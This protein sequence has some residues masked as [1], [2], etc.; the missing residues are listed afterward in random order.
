MITYD[1]GSNGNYLSKKGCITAGLPILR[2]STCMVGVANGGTSQAKHVT[3][4]PFH[5][6]SARARQVD[7]FQDFPTLLM[8]MGK[9]SNNNTVSVFTKTGST[10]H[11]QGQAHPHWHTR[12]KG[13]IPN[14]NDVT[15]G[16]VATE[17]PIQTSAEGPTTGQQCLQP[18]IN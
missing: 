9:A 4:L 3:Q 7:S 16:T 11:M 10:H 14:T 12:W 8:S 1:S 2:P 15:T 17:V 18:P 6:L 5:K 13:T